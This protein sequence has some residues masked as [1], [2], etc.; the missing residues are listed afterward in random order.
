[1]DQE[2]PQTMGYEAAGVVDEIGSDVTGV[3][4]GDEVVGFGGDGA[5]QAE[6]AVLSTLAPIPE[7]L[8]L[9]RRGSPCLAVPG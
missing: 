8:G 5:A 2:L 7:S 4:I 3:Q 9:R 1:M 6:Y